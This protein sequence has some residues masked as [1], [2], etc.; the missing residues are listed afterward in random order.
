MTV[1][2]KNSGRELTLLLG[3]RNLKQ[4]QSTGMMDA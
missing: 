3:L 2:E 4:I 1:Q